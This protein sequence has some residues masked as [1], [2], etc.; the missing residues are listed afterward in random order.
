MKDRERS[1]KP[2]SAVAEMM[3]APRRSPKLGF[4][5]ARHGFERSSPQPQ[6]GDGK[7]E[8]RSA[9]IFALARQ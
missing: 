5:R 9:R 8:K 2:I 6:G 4:K 1:R 3:D 7:Q